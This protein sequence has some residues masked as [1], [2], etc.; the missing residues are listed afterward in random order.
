MNPSNVPPTIPPEVADRQRKARA[1]TAETRELVGYDR[2]IDAND[3]IEQ[4][5]PGVF[6][7]EQRAV[8]SR[9]EEWAGPTP[10]RGLTP[11]QILAVREMDLPGLP[12][13]G[14]MGDRTPE[15]V[16]AIWN[17]YP[18]LAAIRYYARVGDVYPRKLSPNWPPK[19]TGESMIPKPGAATTL[20]AA[21]PGASFTAEQVQQLIQGAVNS[22]ITA[23][24]RPAGGVW[25]EPALAPTPV[26]VVADPI[27]KVDTHPNTDR[28]AKARAAKA[29]KKFTTT[30]ETV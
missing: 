30:H 22:A 28:L 20:A 2:T 17:T 5:R 1:L 3:T 10:L 21:V 25:V 19:D 27:P 11:E 29:A 9:A 12:Q 4:N 23:M 14:V 7:P 6:T 15:Y 13:M 26:P 18:R 8:M 16:D 24:S